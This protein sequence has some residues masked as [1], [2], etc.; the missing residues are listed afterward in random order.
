MIYTH[1]LPERYM[2]KVEIG[3]AHSVHGE[4]INA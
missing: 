4:T 2:T 3:G 1:H